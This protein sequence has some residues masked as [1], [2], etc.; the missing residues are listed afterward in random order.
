MALR[1]GYAMSNMLKSQNKY[2]S[3]HFLPDVV[4]Q[5]DTESAVHRDTAHGVH[6]SFLKVVVADSLVVSVSR[7]IERCAI[8]FVLLPEYSFTTPVQSVTT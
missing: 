2:K 6:V 5:V 3:Y 4:L 1:S 8:V 7:R